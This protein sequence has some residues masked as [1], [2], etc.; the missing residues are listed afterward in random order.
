MQQQTTRREFLQRS[1]ETAA[2]AGAA[3]ALAGMPV[4]AAE[5]PQTVRLGIIGCDGIMRHHVKGLVKRGNE[6]SIGWLCDVDPQ[7][8]ERMHSFSGSDAATVRQTSRYE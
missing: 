3:T 4:F 8:I 2:I 5:K 6:V 7:Q 1:T